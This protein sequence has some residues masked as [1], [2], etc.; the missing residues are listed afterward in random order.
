MEAIESLGELVQKNSTEI[1]ESA[2]F[3]LVLDSFIKV[4]NDSNTKVALKALEVFEKVIPYM[5]V[6]Y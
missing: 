4:F 2:K 3:I 5:K 1:N 6:G